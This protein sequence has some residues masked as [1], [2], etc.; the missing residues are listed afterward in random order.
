[1]HYFQ[2]SYPPPPDV[3]NPN[4]WT[5]FADRFMEFLPRLV[6]ALIIFSIGLYIAKLVSKLVRLGLEKRKVKLQIIQLIS[7]ITYWS[8][9]VLIT[10]IA[11]STVGVNLSAFLAGLGII[12]FTVGFA[13]QDVSKNFVAGLLLLISQPFQIGDTISVG[14][15]TGV[16]QTIELRA[17]ELKMLDGRQVLIPN[18]DV[19]SS[20]L[21]NFTRNRLRRVE[22]KCGVA[23]GTDLEK[24]RQIALDAIRSIPGVLADPAPSV[25]YNEFGGSSILFSLFYWVDTIDL[26]FL[27]MSD[28]GVVALEQAFAQA[29][30]DIPYPTRVV[31]L[32]QPG[33]GQTAVQDQ[34]TGA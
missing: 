31:Q 23:Y 3:L 13:L 1:M 9:V 30:I 12:G 11:L 20:P 26:K 18:A 5:Q 15:Y 19:F 32:L 33:S 22:I 16:V 24:A 29:G 28:A 17:T 7:R 34:N 10:T 6:I 14:G 25:N 21:T 4:T 2:D 27:D 8:V